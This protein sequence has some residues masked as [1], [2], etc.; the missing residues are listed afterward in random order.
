MEI[1]NILQGFIYSLNEKLFRDSVMSFSTKRFG[2]QIQ[3]KGTIFL[4]KDHLNFHQ[5]RKWKL[6]KKK[7]YMFTV[8][9]T[10]DKNRIH[11][12]AFILDMNHQTLY[13]FDPGHNLYVHGAKTIIPIVVHELVNN[14]IVTK[15][16]FFKT[17]CPQKYMNTMFGIQYNG[18]LSY[19][20][21]KSPIELCCA[22]AF[23]QT[24]TLFFLQTYLNNN[25]STSFFKLWCRIPPKFRE[26][27]LLQQFIIPNIYQNPMINKI[28]GNVLDK[29]HEYSLRDFWSIL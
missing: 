26:Q 13:C 21:S 25:C 17:S 16:I 19:K 15:K 6:M 11:F 8:A 12:V 28:Y 24:W 27:F 23:C 5:Y 4:D 22:D 18:Q 29:L 1:N 2:N 20:S 7:I 9:Y 3:W 10:Y 14:N